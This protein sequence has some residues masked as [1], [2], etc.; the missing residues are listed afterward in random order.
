[1]S[2]PLGRAWDAITRYPGLI[3]VPILWDL[4]HAAA[5]WLTA[6]GAVPRQGRAFSIKFL[7]PQTIPSGASLLEGSLNL[8]PSRSDLPL[9]PLSLY[10]L[11][12]VVGSLVAAGFLHLLQAALNEAPPSWDGFAEGINRYGG[13][14]VLW[15]LLSGAAI[16]VGGILAVN[17]GALSLLLIG[18]GLIAAVL[19]YLVPYLIVVEDL[20]VG[21]AFSRSPGELGA[22][23]GPL[24]GVALTSV[25]TSALLSFAISALGAGLW[26]AIPLWAFFGTWLTLGVM[27]TLRP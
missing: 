2:H 4:V 24:F 9:L 3:A 25:L 6:E 14:L 7:L 20:Q 26:L 27:A 17:M 23:L 12:A 18:V 16:L 15:N 5:L 19:Y 13:R 22:R 8:L 10:M 1:M 11:L 21:D